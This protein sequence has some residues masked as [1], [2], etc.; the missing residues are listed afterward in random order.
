MKN[1]LL[2]FG[3]IFTI[4]SAFPTST[5]ADDNVATGSHV[6]TRNI[7]NM[8]PIDL[9]NSAYQG[10]FA[11]LDIPSHGSFL[12]AIR[13]KKIDSKLLVKSAIESG[14]LDSEKIN[15]RAYLNQVQDL[16][17]LKTHDD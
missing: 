16:L 13:T 15:D 9:V 3:L 10:R 8:A 7:I 14:R 17:E 4:I 11:D 6:I 1:K 2:G 12:A 5:L